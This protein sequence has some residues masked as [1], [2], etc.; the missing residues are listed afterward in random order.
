MLFEIKSSLSQQFGLS[1]RIVHSH[2]VKIQWNDALFIKFIQSVQKH[3]SGTQ[4]PNFCP[5]NVSFSH[6]VTVRRM[7]AETMDGH[8]AKR[9]K[10]YKSSNPVTIVNT[11]LRSIYPLFF[12]D[13]TLTGPIL[14]KLS[15]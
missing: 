15:Y 12:E 4:L 6:C 10:N 13:D 1:I 5:K 3:L 2:Y 11:A 7:Y 14:L 9:H 8:E